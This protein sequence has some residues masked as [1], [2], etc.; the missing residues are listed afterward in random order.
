[1]S[2]IQNPQKSGWETAVGVQTQQCSDLKQRPTLGPTAQCR[3][4]LGR[5]G[6]GPHHSHWAV[7]KSPCLRKKG[8]LSEEAREGEQGLLELGG[9]EDPQL[10]CPHRDGASI[11]LLEE[12]DCH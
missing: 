11:Q 2:H 8:L 6:G 9:G 10:G 7:R 1:M 4:C 3:G 5:V 12:S